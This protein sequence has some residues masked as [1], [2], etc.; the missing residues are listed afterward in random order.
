MKKAI[1]YGLYPLLLTIGLGMSI[2][3][4]VYDWNLGIAYTYIA[5][6]R[7]AILFGI[8]FLFPIEKKWKMTWKSFYRDIKY[9]ITIG[10]TAYL[11]KF[12]IGLIAIQNAHF[13]GIL[14]GLPIALSGII[15]LLAYEF[16]Q[17]WFH[18]I[19]HEAKGKFGMFLW[20]T[21]SIHHLPDK[22][23]LLMHAVGHPINAIVVMLISQIVFIGMGAN[24]QAMLLIN[25]IISLQGLVSHYNVDIRAGWFNYIFIGTEL[26]R[27]HHSADRNEG[28]NFGAILSVWD[29]VFGTFDYKPER[30]PKEIG[31]FDPA[32]YPDS[33]DI[34]NVLKFPFQ[35]NR[36][37]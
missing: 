25:T 16:L 28:K 34:L 18:R 3:S 19:S 5:I 20:K 21:H 11:F 17:Y 1:T 13:K 33:S 35:K 24:G 26:H 14:T 27:Y 30:P 12:F 22:I 9:F 6:I 15:A 29:L 2:L 7:F 31:V 36:I 32:K 23:Y 8:E 37:D 10:S 4:I